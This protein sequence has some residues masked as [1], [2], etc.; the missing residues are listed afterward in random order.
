MA[1]SY[2]HEHI[3]DERDC[4]R[5]KESGSRSCSRHMRGG[6]GD[7]RDR[8]RDGAYMGGGSYGGQSFAAGA[9]AGTWTGGVAGFG[10]GLTPFSCPL[11]PLANKETNHRVQTRAAVENLDATIE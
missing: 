1:S 9:F 7:G 8:D 10:G 2:C 6:G 4:G 5:S 11:S 3:C